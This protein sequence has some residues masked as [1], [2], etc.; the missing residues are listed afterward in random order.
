[1]ICY[2]LDSNTI[3]YMLRNEGDAQRNF[4]REIDV[5]GNKYTIPFIVMH[6]VKQWLTYRPTKTSK[7]RNEKFDE[8]FAKVIVQAEMPINVWEKATEIYIELRSK[9]QMIGGA[10]IL[11]AAYC[12]VN[13]YTLVTRNIKDFERIEGLRLVNWF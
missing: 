7:E 2:T 11:I 13:G 10:D 4:V 12:L 1:M 8:L 6:E 9:G 3:S 5:F